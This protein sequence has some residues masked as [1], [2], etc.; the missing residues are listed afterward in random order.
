[1]ESRILL[2][3]GR[4]VR[5]AVTPAL[6]AE[7]DVLTDDFGVRWNT[8][9]TALVEDPALGIHIEVGPGAGEDLPADFGAPTVPPTVPEPPPTMPAGLKV[10]TRRKRR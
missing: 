9:P 10:S 1:M 7:G 2:V 3:G 5:V 6:H 8:L 4:E